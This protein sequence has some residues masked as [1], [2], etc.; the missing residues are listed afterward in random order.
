MLCSTPY[1]WLHRAALLLLTFGPLQ[2]IA[3]VLAEDNSLVHSREQL[4]WTGLEML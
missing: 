1:R 4:K 3:E 2:P